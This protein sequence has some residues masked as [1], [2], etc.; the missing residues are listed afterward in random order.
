MELDPSLADAHFALAGINLEA[1]DWPAAEREYQCAIKMKPNLAIARGGYAYYLSLMG[2]HERAIEEVK[3]ARE[4]DPLSLPV[5]VGVGFILY[6]ARQ[7][8]QSI[9]VLN[10][11]LEL[12]QDYPFAHLY[13]GYNYAAKA[14]YKA[15]ITAFRKAIERGDNTLN[16]Q[17][18]LGVAYAKGG[19]RKKAQ[20]ILKSLQASAEFVSPCKLA[21]LCDSLGER[22]QAFAL[23][24]AAYDAHDFQLAQL[25]VEPAFDS[26]RK[27]KRFAHLLRRV[28]L[29]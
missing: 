2:Q 14:M 5:N 26:L 16:A 18:Y 19:Q 4:L 10:E 13:I 1:W 9:A 24:E 6:F 12:D 27:D 28:G 3:L 17:V 25:R 11:V 20:A 15:A 8:D 22:E 29:R 23:L 7:Y 21:V